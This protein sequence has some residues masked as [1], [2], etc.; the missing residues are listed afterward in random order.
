MPGLCALCI[1]NVPWMICLLKDCHLKKYFKSIFLVLWVM[2]QRGVFKVCLEWFYWGLVVCCFHRTCFNKAIL[3]LYAWD[4]G[5]CIMI[6]F[7]SHFILFFS[8]FLHCTCV[9]VWWL[10]KIR[11]WVPKFV[12]PV[13]SKSLSTSESSP[14]WLPDAHG[15]PPINILWYDIVSLPST[16]GQRRPFFL[17]QLSVRELP[18]VWDGKAALFSAASR[19]LGLASAL[20]RDNA[21]I[22]SCCSDAM[23]HCCFWGYC[24]PTVPLSIHRRKH[25]A[26]SRAP[27]H[28]VRGSG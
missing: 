14:W 2:R 11:T 16:L 24:L 22:H 10:N 3:R 8:F 19:Y 28:G 23:S 12:G 7:F 26:P 6:L 17:C 4:S 27:G 15:P 5:T 21:V 18:L 1:I 25:G 13:Q 9:R 20:T